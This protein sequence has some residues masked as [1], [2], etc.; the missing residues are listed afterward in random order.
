MYFWIQEKG[1]TLLDDSERVDPSEYKN[2]SQHPHILIDVREK[3]ELEFC[4]LPNTT[5][6]LPYSRLPDE[7][8][9]TLE[10]YFQKSGVNPDFPGNFETF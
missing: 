7:G 10:Q 6:N 3:H 9:H 1:I 8:L 5:L 2:L 4:A